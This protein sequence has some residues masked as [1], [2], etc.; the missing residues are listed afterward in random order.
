ML[1]RCRSV[2]RRPSPSMVVALIALLLAAGGVSYAVIP[3]SDGSINGCYSKRDGS[4]RVIDTA[5]GETC[6]SRESAISFASTDAAGRV[7]NADSLDGKDSTEFLSSNTAAGGNLTGTYPNPAIAP[8]AVRGGI[9]GVI[10]DN[11]VE[12]AD[13]LDNSVR[14]EDIFE[15]TLGKVPDA[16][17][18]DGKDSTEFLGATAK[19]A[20]ADKLDGKNSTEFTTFGGSVDRSGVVANFSRRGTFSVA[21][22]GTGRYNITL[23][24]GTYASCTLPT[25]VV[26][27]REVGVLAD[28][29]PIYCSDGGA[30]TMM[31]ETDGVNG[32]PKDANFSFIGF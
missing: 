27:P 17:T 10:L 20:D 1:R 12:G 5:A 16:D 32:E 14:G 19:A 28:G 24:S 29:K 30:A 9:G 18:L 21:K 15:L 6:A 4:L 26:S 23:P 8:G 2:V 7:A 11:S 25:I 22:V 31:V 13:I 3:N